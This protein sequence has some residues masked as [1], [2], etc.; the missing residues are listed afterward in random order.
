MGFSTLSVSF[1]GVATAC[2]VIG[3]QC[4]LLRYSKKDE[5]EKTTGMFRFFESF[6]IM[7]SPVFCSVT[8]A[9]G[10]VF[11]CYATIGIGF[12]VLSPLIFCK[13]RSARQIW[14]AEKRELDLIR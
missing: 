2:H 5:R 6:G 11:L 4:L 8:V 13:L 3:E 9:I 10:G 7:L 1:L 14:V 12:L